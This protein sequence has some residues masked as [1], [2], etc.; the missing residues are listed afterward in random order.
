MRRLIL[1]AL[2]ACWLV[3]CPM[4]GW[5]Q[6]CRIVSMSCSV[7]A[8]YCIG[9]YECGFA[10]LYEYECGGNVFYIQGGCCVCT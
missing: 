5:A 7:P 3:S 4:I 10:E 9:S 6:S 8:R 2:M 1:V